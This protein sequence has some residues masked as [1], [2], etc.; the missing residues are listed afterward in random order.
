[1]K[2]SQKL[3]IG[4][5]FL[6][7]VATLVWRVAKDPHYMVTGELFYHAEISERAVA[8]TFDDGPSPQNTEDLLLLLKEQ[9]I[10]ATFFMIGSNLEKYPDIAK[11]VFTAGH[12]IGNHTYSHQRTLFSSVEFFR[13][14]IKQ[15]DIL[16]RN[17]GYNDEIVFRPPFG[18]KLINLPLALRE[19]K[20]LAVTWDVESEDTESQDGDALAT[21]V[22]N[23]VKPG[24]VILF[25]DGFARKEGTLK[26]VRIVIEA[27]KAQ[28]YQFMTVN[29]LRS[30]Q[31]R[32]R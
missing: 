2:R 30:L 27:L 32:P 18:K 11:D 15:T 22:L 12:Q 19:M 3:L 26:A 24:S 17:L 14:E 7:L 4:L 13:G 9:K 8:L 20:K 23:Q 1:M 31:N 5:L 25:H 29:E 21:R 6:G 28:G 16:I 10:P